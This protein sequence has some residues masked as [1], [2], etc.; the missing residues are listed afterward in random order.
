MA[1]DDV[2]TINYTSGTT[3]DPKGVCRTHRNEVV[4]ALLLST[5][6]T[7]TDTDTYLWTLPMFH[8]NGWGHIF[9]ITGAGATHVCTRASTPPASSTPSRPKPCRTCV[10]P[11]PS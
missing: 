5:H 10:P 11:R 6:H 4:H 8:A 7:I 1:E 3:G 9:A 2:I